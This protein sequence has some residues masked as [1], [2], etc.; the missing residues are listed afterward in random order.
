MRLAVLTDLYANR[1]VFRS[2]PCACG[3]STVP[4]NTPLGDLIGYGADP[5]WVL[6]TVISYVAN[7]AQVLMGNH[8]IGILQE[9]RKEMNAT[10]RLV[11]EGRARSIEP[12]PSR[13]YS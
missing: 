7:G 4:S 1:E 8:D 5:G 13:L 11:V 9:D 10:A 2:L 6:D 12:I 3:R